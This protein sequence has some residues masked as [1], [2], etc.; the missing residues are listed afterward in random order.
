MRRGHCDPASEI[1][2]PKSPPTCAM[3]GKAGKS[4]CPLPDRAG[5]VG[6]EDA[7]VIA[8]QFR[9]RYTR[10]FGRPVEGPEIEIVT[11]SVKAQT[12]LDRPQV[13]PLRSDEDTVAPTSVRD[14][15]DPDKGEMLPH[16]LSNGTPWHR[17]NAS[18]ARRRLPKPKQRSSFRP[19][20]RRYAK[21]MA[22]ST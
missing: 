11:L 6:P 2:P 8:T 13:T 5:P 18:A 17:G 14:V 21:A 1:R 22:A 7:A 4:R 15:F 20:A 3:P 10:F 9:D 19:H 16:G 12:D